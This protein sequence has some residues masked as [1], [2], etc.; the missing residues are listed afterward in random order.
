MANICADALLLFCSLT[1]RK[2]AAIHTAMKRNAVSICL[3]FFCMFLSPFLRVS[4]NAML[5]LVKIRWRNAG[6]PAPLSEPQASFRRGF[7][8]KAFLP[9]VLR[10]PYSYYV[11]TKSIDRSRCVPRTSTYSSLFSATLDA[12]AFTSASWISL[13]VC[14]YLANVYS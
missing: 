14:S 4:Y 11:F 3:L 10:S 2:Y 13:G 7:V 12:L 1:I 5:E 9:Q 8:I 6:K